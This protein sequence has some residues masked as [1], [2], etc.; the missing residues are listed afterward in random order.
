VKRFA[1]FVAVF[2]AVFA[3]TGGTALAASPAKFYD[4]NVNGNTCNGVNGTGGGSVGTARW[5][6]A[7]ATT[8]TVNIRVRG[9][10]PNTTYAVRFWTGAASCSSH[11][12][13]GSLTTDARGNASSS[14][15][16]ENRSSG[17]FDLVPN[18]GVA[19]ATQ[20]ITF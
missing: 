13:L 20:L 9:L 2:A 11:Q 10:Q 17:W 7:T 8:S 6:P 5:R 18:S 14:Y 3:L 1:R 16:F 4:Q 12:E 15:T 19:Y